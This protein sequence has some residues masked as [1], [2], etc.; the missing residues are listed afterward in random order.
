MLSVISERKFSTCFLDQVF[1][2]RARDWAR[3]SSWL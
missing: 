2:Q 1:F 3:R